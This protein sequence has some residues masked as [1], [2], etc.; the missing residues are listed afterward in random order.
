MA[1]KF[2]ELPFTRER[3]L[4]QARGSFISEPQTCPVLIKLAAA[5]SLPY[6]ARPR[7]YC[8]SSRFAQ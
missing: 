4:P 3:V 8:R 6:L 5:P 7:L 1:L 2:I